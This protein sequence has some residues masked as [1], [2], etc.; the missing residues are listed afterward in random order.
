MLLWIWCNK[1]RK[2][3]QENEELTQMTIITS[4][5]SKTNEAKKAIFY[6][7]RWEKFFSEWIEWY[8]NRQFN[9]ST[10]HLSLEHIFLSNE[11]EKQIMIN[12]LVC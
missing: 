8:N 5:I 11:M 4:R 2:T 10:Q 6:T 9:I 12:I 3:K 7:E 1:L